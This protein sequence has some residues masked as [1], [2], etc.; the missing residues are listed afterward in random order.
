MAVVVLVTD[1][2]DGDVIVVGD[3]SAMGGSSLPGGM[4]NVGRVA[5]IGVRAVNV[6]T[7]EKTTAGRLGRVAIGLGLIV[8]SFVGMTLW[9]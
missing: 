7:R 2:G 8:T 5:K 3:G 6:I 1:Q 9:K 4:P